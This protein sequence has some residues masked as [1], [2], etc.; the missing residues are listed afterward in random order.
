MTKENLAE[1]KVAESFECGDEREKWNRQRTERE[2]GAR[3]Q[4]DKREIVEEE[5]GEEEE[6]ESCGE[7]YHCPRYGPY[8]PFTLSVRIF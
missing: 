3:E 2:I 8:A 1:K 7:I 5:M 6:E 4:R